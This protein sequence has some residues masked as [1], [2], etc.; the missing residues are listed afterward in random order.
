[1]FGFEKLPW[2]YLPDTRRSLG[3][4]PVTAGDMTPFQ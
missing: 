4:D 1:M 3:G 2:H